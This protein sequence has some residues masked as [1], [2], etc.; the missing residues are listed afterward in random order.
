M[1]GYFEGY[2]YPIRFIYFFAK[3][4]VSSTTR[5]KKRQRL[6]TECEFTNFGVNKNTIVSKFYNDFCSFQK[7]LIQTSKSE[8]LKL[9]QLA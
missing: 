3:K 9:Q 8:R 6:L 7:Q 1:R 4:L 5:S 2:I